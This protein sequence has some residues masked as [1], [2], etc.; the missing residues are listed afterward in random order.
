MHVR[1][2]AFVL[3]ALLAAPC[4]AGLVENHFECK[5]EATVA[6]EFEAGLE[7]VRQALRSYGVS[8]LETQSI[9]GGRRLEHYAGEPPTE[10]SSS[11]D[12]LWS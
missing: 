4:W 8:S 1:V 10:A 3:A 9:V 11:E 6:A 12:S 2:A 7:M 5:D